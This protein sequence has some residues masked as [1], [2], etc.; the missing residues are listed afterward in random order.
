[1]KL[2]SL[3]V[4]VFKYFGHL[5]FIMALILIIVIRWV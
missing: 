5:A 2:N 3:I 1:M 4:E